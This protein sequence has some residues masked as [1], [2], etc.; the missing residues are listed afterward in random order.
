MHPSDNRGRKAGAHVV[1]Q[2][3]VR[4]AL[5]RHEAFWKRQEVNR[6]LVQIRRDRKRLENVDVFPEML[7]IEELTSHVGEKSPAR[8]LLHQDL[9]HLESAFPAVPWLEAILGCPVHAGA[10]EVMAPQPTLGPRYEGIERLAS[11]PESPW[12]RKLLDLTRALVD[13]NDGSY[14]V[15]HALMRGPIDILAALLGNERMTQ[16]LHDDPDRAGEILSRAAS[17]FVDVAWEQYDLIPS[18][19]GGSAPWL[20]GVWAP[21]SA[22]RLQCDS[23]AHISPDIYRAA[24]LPHDRTILEA[25]DYT[26]VD[27]HTAGTLNLHPILVQEAD[28]SALAVTLD[29]YAGAP[30][31]SE[32][33]PALKTILETKSLVVYGDVTRE[34]LDTLLK[35]PPRGLCLNLRV[36][37]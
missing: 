15:T 19:H 30:T 3:A 5:S 2:A 12:L 34:E 16:S 26:L 17:A 33:L 11:D 21:G 10:A 9:F 25:F 13:R 31:M 36:T 32:I 6:P 1:D 18:F 23:A 7:D 28:V 8:S 27:L 29:R 22:I 20:Y 14:I 4:Q 37:G 24:V 35:L